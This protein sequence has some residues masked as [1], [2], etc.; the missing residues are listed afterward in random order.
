MSTQSKVNA[1][2]RSH[3][4]PPPAELYNVETVDIGTNLSSVRHMDKSALCVTNSTASRE[5]AGVYQL[6]LKVIV[7]K[8]AHDD[9]VQQP[10]RIFMRLNRAIQF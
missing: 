7:Y 6:F 8:L 1:I 4:Q 3:S 5:Y 9:V 2:E 10:I